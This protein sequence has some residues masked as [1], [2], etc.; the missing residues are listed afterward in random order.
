MNIKLLALTFSILTLVGCEKVSSIAGSSVKCD[1]EITKQTFVEAF[2]KNV[3]EIASNRV[4]EI[5]ETENVTVDMGKLRSALQQI[6]FNVT[7]VRTNNADPNS[8]KNYCV[9]NLVVNIPAQMIKDADA[10]RAV[11]EENNI[12][13]AA[14]LS[15]LNFENNQLKKEI[16][17]FVQPT[18]DGK[19]VFVTLENPDALAVFVRDIAID[20]LLKGARQNAAELAK[21]EEMKRLAEESAA[22]EEYQSLLITEA[23]TNLDQANENLNLVWNATTKD[24]REQLLKEQRIWLKKRD[25]ECKLQ[26]SNADNPEVSRL[27]CETNMTRE[28]T[29]ELR[30]KI[31]YLEP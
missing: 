14:V 22:A 28:R 15:D 18:D 8:K 20:S 29:N 27:N 1:S 3:A 10:A 9:T 21:Q 11:Y 26:S 23:Q 2:S 7:D 30:Q 25:L 12:S 24:V 16:E 4:K 6:T 13:Q 17:Y 19:K 5:I 31:Y